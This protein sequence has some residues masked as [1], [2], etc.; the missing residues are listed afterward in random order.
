M[1]QDPLV[2][3]ARRVIKRVLRAQRWDDQGGYSC[4]GGNGKWNFAQTSIGGYI[5]S[6]E[7]NAL[8]AFAGIVPDKIVSLGDCRNCAN[9]EDGHEQ[10]YSTKECVSCRRPQMSNF[11]PMKRRGPKR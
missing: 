3:A 1:S 7:Y 8:F 6:E 10:G 2:E 4:Y 11:V 9:S 5:T